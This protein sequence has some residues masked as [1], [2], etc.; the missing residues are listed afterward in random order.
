MQSCHLVQWRKRPPYKEDNICISHKIQERQLYLHHE[1]LDTVNNRQNPLASLS[2]VDFFQN[3]ER[4]AVS[5]LLHENN[6]SMVLHGLCNPHTILSWI[7][8]WTTWCSAFL[9]ESNNR[10]TG[11]CS[12]QPPKP[13]I[14]FWLWVE[15]THNAGPITHL[16]HVQAS[17]HCGFMLWVGH[18]VVGLKPILWCIVGREF[19]SVRLTNSL[20]LWVLAY[21][22]VATVIRAAWERTCCWF[23][24]ATSHSVVTGDFEDA[25]MSTQ[26]WQH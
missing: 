7:Y 13:K 4:K 15:P 23:V 8:S 16:P 1:R 19:S 21:G 12:L 11:V 24:D 6:D 2:W 22:L 3:L 9:D 5:T 14:E 18:M 26:A 10:A 20:P 17:L 25:G